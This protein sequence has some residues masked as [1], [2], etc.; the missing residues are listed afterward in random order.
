[1]NLK[2]HLKSF[3][4]SIILTVYNIPRN[5]DDSEIIVRGVVSPM[6]IS[7]KRKKVK[8]Q[9]FLAGYG[10]NEVSV[11]RRQFTTD[12]FCK[13]H[14]MK[15]NMG[16]ENKY[17]GVVTFLSKHVE[18]SLLAAETGDD[19]KL[20]ASPIIARPMLPMHADI[21]FPSKTIKGEAN[22]DYRAFATKLAATSQLYLDPSPNI[23]GPWTGEPLTWEKDS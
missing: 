13:V 17:K 9:A 12:T 4:N 8:H 5:I 11:L 3:R 21:L 23:T 22:S 2:Q 19:I 16:G 10:S 20:S 18:E 15:I 7:E 6:F 1:L 14:C